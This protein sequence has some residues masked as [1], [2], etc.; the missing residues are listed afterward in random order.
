MQS[1]DDEGDGPQSGNQDVV[2]PA[3]PPPK[4]AESPKLSFSVGLL[5]SVAC[6]MENGE[7]RQLASDELTTNREV[8]VQQ[9]EIRLKKLVSSISAVSEGRCVVSS[10]VR[11]DFVHADMDAQSSFVRWSADVTVDENPSVEIPFSAA[12]SLAFQRRK[13]PVVENEPADVLAREIDLHLL[14]TE[15]GLSEPEEKVRDDDVVRFSVAAAASMPKQFENRMSFRIS[16]HWGSLRHVAG[17]GYIL[18]LIG[19]PAVAVLFDSR[20]DANFNSLP[21]PRA[22]DSSSTAPW[23]ADQSKE[24]GKAAA[25]VE[26][27]SPVTTSTQTDAASTVDVEVSAGNETVAAVAAVTTITLNAVAAPEFSN[28]HRFLLVSY[29]IP[30]DATPFYFRNEPTRYASFSGAANAARK[31]VHNQFERWNLVRYGATHYASIGSTEV[32]A[33][34]WRWFVQS[35]DGLRM[36]ARAIRGIVVPA[37]GYVE[38]VAGSPDPRYQLITQ[39]GGNGSPLAVS[40]LRLVYDLTS[41]VDGSVRPHDALYTLLYHL[42]PLPDGAVLMRQN[43]NSWR[44]TDDSH[45]LQSFPQPVPVD[46]A[47]SLAISYIRKIASCLPDHSVRFLSVWLQCSESNPVPFSA[48]QP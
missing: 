1:G 30:T 38:H 20:H 36:D 34:L 26:L 14:L 35:H 47:L 46:H 17:T 18:G 40:G 25:E 2:P 44:C 11:T 15:K 10:H 41:R 39:N 27:T 45:W 19:P 43:W 16:I 8:I 37:V 48:I 22:E 21:I 32:F 3:T 42:R 24:H 33:Q 28:L 13:E 31:V 12:K 5:V 9:L 4:T 6:G 7:T 23:T 29:D